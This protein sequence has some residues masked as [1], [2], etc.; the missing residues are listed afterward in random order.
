MFVKGNAVLGQDRQV[1]C[2]DRVNMPYTDAVVY[3]CLR[4]G[5]VAQVALPHVADKDLYVDEV[6]S[7]T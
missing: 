4:K 2:K 7:E 3:E 1:S 5:N 6:V